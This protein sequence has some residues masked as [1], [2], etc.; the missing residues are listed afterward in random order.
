VIRRGSMVDTVRGPATLN[1]LREG[2]QMGGMLH[3]AS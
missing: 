1:A 3:P 2:W